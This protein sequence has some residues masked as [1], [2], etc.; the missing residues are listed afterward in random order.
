MYDLCGVGF[1]IR[2]LEYL[3]VFQTRKLRLALS[4]L[5]NS[6]PQLKYFLLVQYKRGAAASLAAVLGSGLRVGTPPVP[7]L[8][9][10]KKQ[11]T[12]T[13]I[14]PKDPSLQIVVGPLR[15]IGT[16]VRRKMIY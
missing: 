4:A 1:T 10:N 7:Y 12:W 15:V 3:G 2:E 16:L 5:R 14:Q 11:N 9:P 6:R 13:A 8:D